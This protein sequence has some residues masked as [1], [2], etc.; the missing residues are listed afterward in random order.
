[1]LDFLKTVFGPNISIIDFDYP[2]ETPYYI[3]DGYILSLLT[4]KDNHCVLLAPNVPSWRLPTIKKQLLNFQKICPLPCALSLENLSAMQRRNLVENDIPFISLTQQ[5]YLPFWGCLFTERFKTELAAPNQMAPGT[6]LVFLYLYYRK[7]PE[8][9]N[10]TQ[11]SKHLLLSKAT[12]TRAINDL[13]LSG[14]IILQS[15]GTYKWV[16]PAFEKPEFLRKAFPRLKSPVE[17][18]IYVKNLDGL[19]PIN[20]GVRGLAEISTVGAN[21]QDGATAA[22][23]KDASRIPTE[24]IISKQE[25]RDFGGHIIEVW[26]YDPLLLAEG[27][28]VDDISLLLSLQM[29]QDER[30]QMGLDEIRKAHKLPIQTE[31]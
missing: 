25:F 27:E 21:E 20:S 23:K 7:S 31:E 13:N 19:K 18:F 14:L 24:S 4:W 11:L 17:R 28:R 5:L 26:S 3:R 15:E 16:S 12:C 6:Q 29:E 2:K 30:I 1:M 9:I 22:S 10:L 8:P